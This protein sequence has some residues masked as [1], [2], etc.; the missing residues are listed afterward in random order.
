MAK[1]PDA[2]FASAGELGR[3]GAWRAAVRRR[4]AAGRRAGGT[5]PRRA[6]GIARRAEAR[7]PALYERERELAASGGR[8][9]TPQRSGSGRVLVIEG[10]AGIGK[11]SLLG[12]V[13]RLAE[14]RGFDVFSATAAWSSS[15]TSRTAW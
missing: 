7:D 3:R 2:R 14:E 10:Q 8:V 15:A 4:D 12:E 6:P 5:R 1:D 9:R 11:S 13:Q